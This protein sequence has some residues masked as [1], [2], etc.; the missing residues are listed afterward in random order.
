MPRVTG[1]VITASVV[2][3][4]CLPTCKGLHIDCIP[5]PFS[6]DS[7]NNASPLSRFLSPIRAGRGPDPPANN[8]VAAVDSGQQLAARR[9]KSDGVWPMSQSGSS[10]C[11]GKGCRRSLTAVIAEG[12]GEDSL[13]HAIGDA[14]VEDAKDSDRKFSARPH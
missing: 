11:H 8:R 5:H 2:G 4:F 7:I 1:R 10:H 9:D 12:M 6:I 3:H 13:T 14:P